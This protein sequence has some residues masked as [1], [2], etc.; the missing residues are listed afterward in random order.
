MSLARFGCASI[1]AA[2]FV[3]AG[4]TLP[5]RG[6]APADPPG[7]PITYD[8][9]LNADREPGNWLMYN[10]TYSG[11]RFSRLD[12]I[13]AQNVRN[14]KVKWLFQGRHVE[15]FETTPLVVDGVMYLTRPENAIYALDAA[16]GTPALDLRA[17]EPGADVQLLRHATTGGWPSSAPRCS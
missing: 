16:H 13:T 7:L 2:V 1:A 4:S 3:A 10:G 15:K 12:Q 14:L 17:Q 5:L 9:L 11:W 6:Q 8:R